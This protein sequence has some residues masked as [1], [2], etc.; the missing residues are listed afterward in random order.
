MGQIA[1]MM[2]GLPMGELIGAPMVSV[3]SAQRDL[4]RVMIEYVNEVGYAEAGSNQARMMEFALTRPVIKGDTITTTN[5]KVQAPVLGV[6]PM[7]SLLIDHV[8]IDFQ[9]EVTASESNSS[10]LS[11]SS[12][13]SGSVGWGP[14]RASVSGKVATSR[15]NT[16]STN[17]TAKYQVHV[18]ANQQPPTECLAKL[19]DLFASCTE[20]LE[21]TP[22]TETKAA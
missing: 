22:A 7:P 17:Q 4:A 11:A 10:Q 8:T 2:G 3:V 13:A 9:M 15:E 6:M 1:E 21:L 18:A 20:P 14:V 16:R 19:M 12:E 5:M